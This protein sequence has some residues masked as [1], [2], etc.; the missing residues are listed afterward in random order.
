[1]KAA[2]DVF[3]SG[4]RAWA[5]CVTFEQWAE[6]RAREVFTVGLEV[7]AAYEAG[8]FYK[9]EL[10]C[11]LA[12]LESAGQRF[13]SIIVDGFVSLKPPLTKGL[14]GR[15]ADS[16]DYHP[17]IIGVAKSPLKLA[18]QYVEIR[19]G[20]SRRPLYISALGCGA[21]EAARQI[22]SMHGRYRIPTLLKLA[23][24]AARVAAR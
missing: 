5:A 14:G 11:L 21:E 8:Q 17:V 2:L 13:D 16:L 4:C 7:P 10:P 15:L 3:Y 24:R 9:R 6:A 23:D 12:A 19:R 20:S 22:L 18:D 1:M